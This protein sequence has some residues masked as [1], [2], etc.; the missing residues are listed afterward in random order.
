QASA[1]VP[2]RAE[3]SAFLIARALGEYRVSPECLGSGQ[4]AIAV[5]LFGASGGGRQDR[6]PLVRWQFA[7]LTCSPF[8]LHSSPSKAFALLHTVFAGYGALAKQLLR[9]RREQQNRARDYCV[10]TKLVAQPPSAVF[11]R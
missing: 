6:I 2:S 5:I 1:V 4:M 11:R 8:R 9:Q 10:T 3:S 7:Q